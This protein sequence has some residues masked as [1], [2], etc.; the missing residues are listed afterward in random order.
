MNAQGVAAGTDITNI[1]IVNY[2]VAGAVQVP[3]ESSPSG[4]SAPGTGNGQG[5]TFNVDRKVDLSISSNGDAT[6]ALGSSQAELSF[7]LINEGNDSQEYKLLTD[8]T[9]GTDDFDTSNCSTTVTGVTPGSPLAGVTLP[10]TGN[11]KLKADQKAFISV[12]CDIPLN[13]NGSQILSGQASLLSL[14]AVT[15]KNIDGS[16]TSQTT[17]PNAISVIDTVFSDDSG[18]DDINRDASHSTRANYI[19]STSGNP[20]PTLAINK[21]IV[22]VKDTSGGNTA[23]TGSEVT[24]K[25]QVTTS[26]IG[27]INDV[28]ITDITP[29]EMNYK[30]TTIKLDGVGLS[31]DDD[32]DKADYGVTNANTA[33]IDLGNINAGNQHEILLTYTIK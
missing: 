13:N 18:T 1:V 30:E 15:E 19:A 31:D 11:I 7:T 21:S 28:L 17:V 32:L 22:D 9:L 20:P 5:T 24:Y 3:I 29:V 23:V 8:S 2:S 25:I 4:N 6:V 10:T 26:G 16:S 12:K 14:L 33:T 27:I